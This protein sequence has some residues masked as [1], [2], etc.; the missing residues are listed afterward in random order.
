ML[1]KDHKQHT[2]VWVETHT[3]T[4]KVNARVPPP[5]RFIMPIRSIS[6]ASGATSALVVFLD[7]HRARG[8]KISFPFSQPSLPHP[9]LFYRT[10]NIGKIGNLSRLSQTIALLQPFF[11]IYVMFFIDRV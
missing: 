8:V 9:V 10:Q 4:V 3:S 1:R 5:S 2:F 7:P 11:M 6:R